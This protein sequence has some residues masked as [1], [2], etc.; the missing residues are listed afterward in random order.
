MDY[1]KLC[2]AIFALHD[3]I[4]YAGVIDDTGLLIAGGMRK[5]IDSVV[6]QTNEELYLA[7][8]ALRKSMRQ[9]FDESMGR[10]RF[11]YVEREKISM[12][13]FYM[14]KFTLL[15]SIEPNVDSHAVIDITKDVQDLIVASNRE[16]R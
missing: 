8:T 13:T 7:Q 4:R 9:R 16:E 6:D 3:D 2:E 10:A 14:E 11:A 1:E 5:G 12:L 15:L